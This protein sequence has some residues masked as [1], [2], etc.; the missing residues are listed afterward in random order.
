MFFSNFPHVKSA[1]QHPHIIILESDELILIHCTI[2]NVYIAECFSGLEDLFARIIMS[3]PVE[4]L[5]TTNKALQQLLVPD[6]KVNYSCEQAVFNGPF[7]GEVKLSVPHQQDLKFI[8]DSYEMPEYIS[9]LND[10][11]RLFAYYQDDCLIGYVAFHIDETVG[12][13]FVKP[14]FRGQGLGLKIMKS[15]FS[16][17]SKKNPGKLVFSQILCENKNSIKLHEKLGC[18][19]ME[20]VHWVFNKEYL[21]N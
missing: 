18:N 6:F 5:Q 11:K 2:S 19:F 1:L 8:S 4:R 16:L 21:Y 14:E 15:A 9:Q 3:F 13:L 17:Y 12:A 20:Q 7:Q 10:R